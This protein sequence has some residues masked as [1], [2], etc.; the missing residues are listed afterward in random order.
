MLLPHFFKTRVAYIREA[1]ALATKRGTADDLGM[2]Y[3]SG[4]R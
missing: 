2:R 3:S 4:R 1:S